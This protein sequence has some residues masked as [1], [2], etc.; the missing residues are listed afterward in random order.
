ME[1]LNYK[2]KLSIKKH[3]NNIFYYIHDIPR[4]IFTNMLDALCET[5]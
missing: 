5:F 3:G 2:F 4:K 1:L